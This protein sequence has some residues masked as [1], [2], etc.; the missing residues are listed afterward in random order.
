MSCPVC[1]HPERQSIDTALLAGTATLTQLSKQHRL[2]TSD[3][4]RH[5]QHLVQKTGQAQNRFQEL[6]REGYLFTLQKF[7]EMV[8]IAADTARAEGDD[9][10]LLQAIRQ[11]TNIMK[12]MAKLDA[13]LTADTIHRLLASPQWAGASLLP[14]D[15]RFVAACRQALADSLLAPCPETV[16]VTNS[17]EPAALRPEPPPDL[18]DGLCQ[19]ES[20]CDCGQHPAGPPH[21]RKNPGENLPDQNIPGNRQL[22]HHNRNLRKKAPIGPSKPATPVCTYGQWIDELDTGRLSLDFLNAVGV[23]RQPLETVPFSG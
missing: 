11:G 19:P 8:Q 18:P 20:V 5:Q 17:A 1:H 16:P 15:P 6:L 3:L 7:L 4:Q 12:F 9:R 13:S 23:G 22:R 10:Q 21:R 14:T 2:N